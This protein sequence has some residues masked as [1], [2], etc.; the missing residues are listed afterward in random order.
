MTM[1]ALVQADANVT[2][3]LLEAVVPNWDIAAGVAAARK[4][5]EAR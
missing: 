3:T 2:D 1:I 4:F 5:L